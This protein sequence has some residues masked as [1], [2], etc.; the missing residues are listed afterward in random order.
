MEIK[1]VDD[2]TNQT[3]ISFNTAVNKIT[4]WI[5]TFIGHIPNMAVA[6]IVFILFFLFA[7]LTKR[8]VERLFDQSSKNDVIKNL[9]TGLVYY[10]VLGLGVFIILEVLN[11]KTAVTSLLAGVGIVGI[12]L[13]FAFQDIA[14]NFL[15][16]IILA[17][18]KPFDILDIVQMGEYT[19]IVAQI[20]IRDTVIK[21]FQGQEVVIPNRSVIQNPIINYTV[22]GER[23]IDLTFR[24]SFQ[25]DLSLIKKLTLQALQP[26]EQIIRKEEVNFAYTEFGHSFIHFEIRFW[27]KYQHEND[28]INTRTK[29]IMEIKNTLDDN[30]ISIPFEI[31]LNEINKLKD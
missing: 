2:L 31:R 13:G 11:L 3:K 10:C 19:G 9:F 16:G 22:L 21:T 1:M 6:I 4:E 28:F 5:D 30:N 7:R 24:A 8:W 12:A 17:Y 29:A 25:E 15:S 27:V 23:R 26:I 20:N 18:R 14:A